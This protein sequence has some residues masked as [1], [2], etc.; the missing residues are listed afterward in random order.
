MKKWIIIILVLVL[1]I[2]GA[3]FFYFKDLLIQPESSREEVTFES[4]QKDPGDPNVLPTFNKIVLDFVHRYDKS[5]YS[6]AG[7][8]LID[9]DGD[10]LEEVFIGR[11]QRTRRRVIQI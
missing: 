11:G 8:A 10:G 9:V 6:F 4:M 2:L 5:M 7:S 1:V 3:A